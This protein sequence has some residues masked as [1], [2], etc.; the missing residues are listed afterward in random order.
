VTSSLHPF[1]RK[2]RPE[3]NK[4]AH[5]VTEQHVKTKHRVRRLGSV[6][7]W[8]MARKIHVKDIL[9][10]ADELRAAAAPP[11]AE[12]KFDQGYVHREAMTVEWETTS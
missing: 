8:T 5:T 2:R 3:R 9:A 11:D 4:M 10:F 6:W 1:S 12:V 7:L